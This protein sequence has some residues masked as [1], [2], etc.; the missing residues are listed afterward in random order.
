LVDIERR[1]FDHYLKEEGSGIPCSPVRIFVM[2]ENRWRD[3]QQWPLARTVYVG[4]QLEGTS[5]APVLP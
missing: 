3:E 1:W 2:G 4:C 5:S